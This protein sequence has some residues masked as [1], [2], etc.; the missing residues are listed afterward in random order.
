MMMF[1]LISILLFTSAPGCPPNQDLLRSI[2][3]P[4]G[5]YQVEI[6]EL[7]PEGAEQRSFLIHEPYPSVRILDLYDKHFDDEDWVRCFSRYEKWVS[8][9]RPLHGEDHLIHQISGYWINEKRKC[10]VIVNLMYDSSVRADENIPDNEIQH[11]SVIVTTASD[12]L[13][14]AVDYLG[15]ACPMDPTSEGERLW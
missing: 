10:I 4:D 15:L 1:A 14:N 6:I 8:H 12:D 11:V 13:S 3:I 2:P 7:T 9:I 5:A